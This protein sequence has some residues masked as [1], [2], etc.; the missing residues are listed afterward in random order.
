MNLVSNSM[1]FTPKGKISLRASKHEGMVRVDVADTGI[2]IEKEFLESV[3]DR[4]VQKTASTLG[5]GVG[6]TI[7]RDI[8]KLHNGRVWAESEGLDRGAIMHVELP[9]AE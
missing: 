2:G 3:F 7:C 5:I 8:V 1:K 6:L 4:F 9:P